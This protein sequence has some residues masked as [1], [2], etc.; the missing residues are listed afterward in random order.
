MKGFFINLG[1]CAVISVS[2]TAGEPA[3]EKTGFLDDLDYGFWVDW[4]SRN[5]SR[6]RDFLDGEGAFSQGAYL[7]SRNF[8]IELNRAG[9]MEDGTKQFNF[10]LYYFREFD[11]FSVSGAYGYSDW[12]SDDIRI[13]GNNVS[14]G[15]TYFDLPAGLWISGDVEYS[16]DRDGFFSDFS[17][18]SDLELYDWLT[19]TPKVS[20]GFNSGFFD[21][22]HEGF[23]HIVASLVADF[24][25]TDHFRLTASAAYNWA[26]NRETD[27]VRY[28]DD[29]ILDNFFWTGFTLSFDGDDQRSRKR[30]VSSQDAWQISLGTSTWATALLGSFA[31]DSDAR[32][33]VSQIDDSYDQFH[34]GLSI[35]ANRGPWSILLEGSYASFGA[36]VPPPLPIFAPSPV[37]VRTAEVQLAGGFR[38]HEDLRA[39]IDLLAGVR[40][41]YL[42]TEDQ[43]SDAGGRKIN[44]LD[45]SVGI[46]ARVELLDNFYASTR[47]ELGGFGMGSDHFWQVDIG[48]DY[49]L[50][51]HLSVELRYQHFEAD[52]AQDD[53]DVQLSFKGPKVGVNYRF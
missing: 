12:E 41:N 20:V 8:G 4:S 30:K 36:E 50:T 11:S 13:D 45:P 25:L 24:F 52:Y 22:G 10:D 49:E 29:A 46:R 6:G 53:S 2:G 37:E 38:V 43:F 31:I 7:G 14:A 23:N 21:E 42:G 18:G 47:A 17:V 26:L 3:N 28:P 1:L 40:F 33:A 48:L 27:F 34:T 39:C 32:S 44:W 19:L 16:I 9:A 15:I 35:E 5:T 51:D